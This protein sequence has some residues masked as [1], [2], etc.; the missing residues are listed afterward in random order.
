MEDKIREIVARVAK[1]DDPASLAVEADIFRDIGV[2]S[3]AA[4]DLLL[5]LE[6]EFEISIPDESFAEARSIRALTDM[7]QDLK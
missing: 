2:K 7:V 4:L 5:S 3:T 1:S 6:E